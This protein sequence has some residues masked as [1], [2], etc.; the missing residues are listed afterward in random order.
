MNEH[1]DDIEPEVEEGGEFE[2]VEFPIL[3]E[4]EEPEREGERPAP[5]KPP[6][7]DPD[8]SEL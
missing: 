5:L 7:D 2:E 4:V 3:T 1:D 8:P 6:D